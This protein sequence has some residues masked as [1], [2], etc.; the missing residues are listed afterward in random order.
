MRTISTIQRILF[1]AS[2]IALEGKLNLYTREI[3]Y[4]QANHF[5]EPALGEAGETFQ[6]EILCFLLLRF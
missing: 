2:K 6:K 3:S 4:Q 1:S 5:Q